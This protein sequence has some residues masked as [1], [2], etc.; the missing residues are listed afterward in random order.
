MSAKAAG[1]ASLASVEVMANNQQAT[2]SRSEAPL[3]MLPTSLRSF[4]S[5]SALVLVTAC[6]SAPKSSAPP[7]TGGPVPAQNESTTTAPTPAKPALEEAPGAA[8]P[9]P[10]TP[11][12]A[13]A[14][15][16]A[17]KGAG[18]AVEKAEKKES[19]AAK[20]GKAPPADG[21]A[22]RRSG[23]LGQGAGAGMGL[24]PC[25]QALLQ[26]AATTPAPGNQA[27]Q[28]AA[29][30]CQNAVAQ[31]TPSDDAVA[32]IRQRLGGAPLPASCR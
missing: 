32:E 28:D 3:A 21:G 10:P 9:P 5:A 13:M 6:S 16:A 30:Y 19:A 12:A 2:L 18:P 23:G 4:G 29:A 20:N 11:P 24:R 14:A 31:A 25:C 7:P 26:S 22:S 27:T 17:D 8:P 1:R 15:P